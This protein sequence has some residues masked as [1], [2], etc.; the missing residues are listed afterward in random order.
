[1]HL[2]AS[3]ILVFFIHS[4]T[5]VYHKCIVKTLGLFFIAAVD[6]T[7]NFLLAFVKF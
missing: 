6:C 2:T 7:R 3:F 1:M 5:C 4:D